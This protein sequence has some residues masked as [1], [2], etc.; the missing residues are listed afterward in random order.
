MSFSTQQ[1]FFN[2]SFANEE[3]K[4]PTRK[5][6][7]GAIMTY[8]FCTDGRAWALDKAKRSNYILDIVH[9]TRFKRALAHPEGEFE[10]SKDYLVNLDVDDL[11]EY[12]LSLQAEIKR[13]NEKVKKLEGKQKVLQDRNTPEEQKLIQQQSAELQRERQEF[14]QQIADLEED[15]IQWRDRAERYDLLAKENE[16]LRQQ[17]QKQRIEAAD[18]MRLINAEAEASFNRMRAEECERLEAELILYRTQ[19][20]DLRAQKRDLKEQLQRAATRQNKVGELKRQLAVERAHREQVE[21]EMEQLMDLFDKQTQEVQRR[22]SLPAATEQRDKRSS[23]QKPV[24]DIAVESAPST[25]KSTAQDDTPAIKEQVV[26]SCS[27]CPKLQ[28]ELD[29][30]KESLR[31]KQEQAERDKQSL[32]EQL[33]SAIKQVAEARSTPPP[34]IALPPGS[35]Q[36]D[37]Q[38]AELAAQ[39]Q[40]CQADLNASENS[41]KSLLEQIASLQKDSAQLESKLAD[42]A[43]KSEQLAA[44]AANA[45]KQTADLQASLQAKDAALS[46]SGGAGAQ[47]VELQKQLDEAKRTLR[48][49]ADQLDVVSK[50]K[51]QLGAKV[52]G[53]E[54]AQK[55]KDM[56]LEAARVE[57]KGQPAVT[58]SVDKSELDALRKSNE[59]LRKEVANLK[60]Q[61]TAAEG[62]SKELQEGAGDQAELLKTVANLK[63]AVQ[64]AA[65]EVQAKEAEMKQLEK[66]VESVKAQA[67]AK[68][69]EMKQLANDVKSAKA[70]AE[71]KEAEIKQLEQVVEAVKVEAEKAKEVPVEKLKEVVEPVAAVERVEEQQMETAAVT[72]VVEVVEKPA[73][74]TAVEGVQEAEPSMEAVDDPTET[75]VVAEEL[76]T[77]SAAI[78]DE[79]T[80]SAAK[81]AEVTEQRQASAIEDLQRRLSRSQEHITALRQLEEAEGE[82]GVETLAVVEEVGEEV[83]ERDVAP[84]ENS[85]Q[86]AVLEELDEGSTRLSVVM[87]EEA[88]GEGPGRTPSV[89]GDPLLDICIVGESD[90][91]KTKRIAIKIVRHGIKILT[92]S[93]L[94]YLHH[95]I[96]KAMIE[97]FRSL[98]QNVQAIDK[99]IGTCNEILAAVNAM[100]NSE[101]AGMISSAAQVPIRN[102]TLLED[103]IPVRLAPEVPRVSIKPKRTGSEAQVFAMFTEGLPANRAKPRVLVDYKS[104]MT[105]SWGPPKTPTETII[106]T[107]LA[108]GSRLYARQKRH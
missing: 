8:D 106:S 93:E 34:A 44:Q 49:K 46:A 100:R 12:A 59:E 103:E 35:N 55:A 78:F 50:E 57:Q 67:E 1:E 2:V 19:Y 68:E 16:L 4:P 73:S 54:V 40:Q 89:V 79:G 17:L 86:P 90:F 31:S 62:L 61:L 51:E 72:E 38:L 37:G 18:K 97:R 26:E 58:A 85:R 39:L 107:T 88:G 52:D 101:M 14:D 96:C 33:E 87:D 43:K 15:I 98:G 41:E 36:A 6:S 104:C 5:R 53:L 27:N 65:E 92:W 24:D 42:E 48:E 56:E 10:L 20:D 94:D 74:A 71:A 9:K 3:P 99:A 21:E 60:N 105:R 77:I 95:E 102:P 70:Q 64:K 25:P 7:D 11:A 69:A 45:S 23:Y 47:L 84:E 29:N 76:E 30:A 13:K 28:A 75:P 32:Q 108:D 22:G 91:D 81:A 80:E 82:P 66:E 63:A 83:G